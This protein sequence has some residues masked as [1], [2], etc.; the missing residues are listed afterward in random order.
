MQSATANS[1]VV[2]S[3]VRAEIAASR[4]FGPVDPGV[5][6]VQVIPIGLVPKN[7]QPGHWRLIVDLSSPRLA[8][9]NEGIATDVCSLSYVRVDE[10]VRR[11][12]QLGPGA[13][14]AKLDIGSAYRQITVHPDDCHLLDVRWKGVV[15]RD[16][17]ILFGAQDTLGRGR[18]S[19]ALEAY[20]KLPA[21]HLSRW[22]KQ[23][24]S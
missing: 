4:A 15:N 23:L 18:R 19:K 17:A 1:S 24:A 3:Y 14:M 16:R 8:S 2:D 11:F 13:L 22:S 6:T 9:V 7:Q 20:I 10:A 5:S 21:R 12:L